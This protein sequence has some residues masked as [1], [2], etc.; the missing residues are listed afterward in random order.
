VRSLIDLSR[1][2]QQL[3]T[4]QA[5]AFFLFLSVLFFSFVFFAFNATFRPSFAR[6]SGEY[7]NVVLY[8]II[9][10]AAGGGEEEE[11][12]FLKNIRLYLYAP[13]HF[14]KSTLA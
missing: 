11:E 12:K 2:E 4:L 13:R 5:A 9:L 6:A 8:I 3:R 10:S 7:L 14:I 1:W